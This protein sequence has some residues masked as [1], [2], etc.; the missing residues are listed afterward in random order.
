MSNEELIGQLMAVAKRAE[1]AG[2][3][4]P[5]I[6]GS[7]EIVKAVLVSVCTKVERASPLVLPPNRPPIF[8]PDAQAP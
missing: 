7:F 8:P 1:Q 6:I 3:P 5:A 4:M 2:R